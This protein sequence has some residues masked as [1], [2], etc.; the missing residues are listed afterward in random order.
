M[1]TT[2]VKISLILSLFSAIF[3]SYYSSGAE[4]LVFLVSYAGEVKA[5]L[6]GEKD[7]AVFDPK[8]PIK[9]GTKILTGDESH[10]IFAFNRDKSNTVK[11]GENTEIIIL[12]NE[13]DKAE[14]SSGTL[15]VSMRSQDRAEYFRVRTAHVLTSSNGAGWIIMSDADKTMI[16]VFDN[17]VY[18]R[19]V[20]PDGSYREE[21]LVTGKG[22]E[23]EFAAHR[24]PAE[25]AEIKGEMALKVKQEA[26]LDFVN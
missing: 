24:E 9:N 5:I 12:P 18:A 10:I 8:V 14:L 2:C 17:K 16:A 3:L 21:E 11:L 19:G 26:G 6:P 4:E 7:P 1:R 15:I 22:Y 20:N 23:R 25:P 13:S